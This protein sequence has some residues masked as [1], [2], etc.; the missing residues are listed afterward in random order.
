MVLFVA[1]AAF[2]GGVFAAKYVV[3]AMGFAY[4]A[5]KLGVQKVKGWF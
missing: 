4:E 1:V 2:V 3:Y 5:V